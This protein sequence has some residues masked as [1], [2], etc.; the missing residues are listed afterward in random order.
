MIEA[1]ER[2]GAKQSTSELTD[3]EGDSSQPISLGKPA[4]SAIKPVVLDHF[5]TAQ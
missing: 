4:T 5:I 2:K 3:G 1:F